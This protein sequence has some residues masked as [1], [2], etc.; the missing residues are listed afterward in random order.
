[1]HQIIEGLNGVEVIADDFLIIGFGD[2]MS[3]ATE[4]RDRNL[5]AFL[6]DAG[7]GT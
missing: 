7:K 5:S 3:E 4:S 1:M 2:T 6:T